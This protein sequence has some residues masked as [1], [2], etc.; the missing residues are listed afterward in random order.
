M[1]YLKFKKIIFGFS[2]LGLLMLANAQ[3][4]TN[5]D[6]RY[7]Y[8]WS[9]NGGWVNFGCRSCNVLV[10]DSSL[11]G[12][13]WVE[14]FGWINLSPS[15]GGVKNDGRGNLSG[16]A[17]GQNI[18]WVDF[19]QV[20]IDQNGK[21]TGLA[22]NS[23]LKN[24]NFNCLNCEVRTSW[25]PKSTSITI[26]SPEVKRT[27]SGGFSA[28]GIGGP[29]PPRNG[30]S[31]LINNDEV[32][33]YN[34][35][36]KLTLNGGDF[37]TYEMVIS[38]FSDFS[39][40]IK[41]PY[42]REKE[43]DLCKGI[44]DCKSGVYTV[45]VR[46]FSL[47]ARGYPVTSSVGASPIVFDRI[48]YI[49][50]KEEKIIKATPTLPTIVRKSRETAQNI[51]S[52]IPRKIVVGM[53]LKEETKKTTQEDKK[54]EIPLV[55]RGNF[56]LL[57]YT[58]TEG[59]L[60]DFTNPEFYEEIKKLTTREVSGQQMGLLALI[61]GANVLNLLFSSFWL[62]LI[63]IILASIG[64]YLFFK[65]QRKAKKPNFLIGQS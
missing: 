65:K 26:S 55:F 32:I 61:G 11:E 25:K 33:T 45:Y 14:N 1:K 38:N 42:K 46:F 31:V 13:I 53:G 7:K 27:G 43:W 62:I 22:T 12:Y 58:K 36:V 44:K 21:F 2:L 49:K 15:K 48:I 5:I 28:G 16:Y 57:T 39:D 50:E 40:A 52:S 10:K 3:V 30:F 59:N 63:I 29:I 60:K 64:I 35:K 47:S 9:D 51:I 17:W 56:K 34:S 24:I 20:K 23:V 18:G 41:E 54:E 8:A 6:S 37:N 4:Q 19:S